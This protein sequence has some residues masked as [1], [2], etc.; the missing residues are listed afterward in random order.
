VGFEPTIPLFEREKMFHALDTTAT[1]IDIV[2]LRNVI[3]IFPC[4]SLNVSRDSAVGIVKGYG[5]DG[6]GSS[7]G[8][9]KTFVSIPQRP[10]RHW[11]PLCFLSIGYRE[12]LSVEGKRQEREADPSPPFVAE[13][14]NG[15]A[16]PSLPP[17]V[18][19]AWCLVN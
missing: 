6:A 10:D 2:V 19:M 7:P 13:V 5:L 8:R 15:G 11:D 17:Y 12:N 14:K 16:I 3:N 1:V 18:L 4:I 9:A